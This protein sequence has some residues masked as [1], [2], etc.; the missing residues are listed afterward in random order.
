MTVYKFSKDQI[1]DALRKSPKF[2]DSSPRE[3]VSGVLGEWAT[4]TFLDENWQR[5]HVPGGTRHD[6]EIYIPNGQINVE[7]KTRS[8]NFPPRPEFN[9]LVPARRFAR[10]V[11]ESGIFIFAWHHY[12]HGTDVVELLGWDYAIF[13][14]NWDLYPAGTP[15]PD[16][17]RVSKY[18]SLRRDIGDL[19]PMSELIDKLESETL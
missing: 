9:V 16:S 17:D 12:E 14:Q 19:R 15:W 18:D 7:I 3:R 1:G 6:L 4:F 5:L 8:A 11:T 2:A 13:V 10:Q